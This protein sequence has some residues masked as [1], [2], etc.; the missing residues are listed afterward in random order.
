MGQVCCLLAFVLWKTLNL[1]LRSRP[2]RNFNLSLG[3]NMK[4]TQKKKFVSRGARKGSVAP[5]D[6]SRKMS[7]VVVQHRSDMLMQE[8]V[9]LNLILVYNL[10]IHF[11]LSILMS[12]SKYNVPGLKS[13]CQVVWIIAKHEIWSHVG[14]FQYFECFFWKVNLSIWA[15]KLDINLS[16]SKIYS[17]QTNAKILTVI[18]IKCL[19]WCICISLF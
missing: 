16:S 10:R 6:S 13:A 14:K 17:S 5:R 3:I 1:H 9:I 12:M 11:N 15:S 4:S 7:K 18:L 2:I 8:Q 19:F